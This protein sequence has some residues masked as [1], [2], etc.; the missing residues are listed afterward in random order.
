MY[1]R[2]LQRPFLFEIGNCQNHV[3]KKQKNNKNMKKLTKK[4]VIKNIEAI[5]MSE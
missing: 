4:A 1:A 3:I 2:V 5:D